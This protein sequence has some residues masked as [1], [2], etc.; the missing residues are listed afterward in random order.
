MLGPSEKA[1]F[2]RSCADKVIERRRL[3]RPVRLRRSDLARV[4]ATT[5]ARAA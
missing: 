4:Y 5:R 1:R 2:G 3:L